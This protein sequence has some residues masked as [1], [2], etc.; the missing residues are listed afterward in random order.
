MKRQILVK[1]SL[2]IDFEETLDRSCTKPRTHSIFKP[3]DHMRCVMLCLNVRESSHVKEGINSDGKA[4][5]V[6]KR[7]D[8]QFRGNF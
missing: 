3:T 5:N 7:F 1:N 4:Y 8:D 2:M 6:Q